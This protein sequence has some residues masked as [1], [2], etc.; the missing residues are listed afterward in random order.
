MT[1]VEKVVGS[2]VKIIHEV[3]SCDF[4]LKH[5]PE[6]H[7]DRC[8]NCGEIFCLKC[9]PEKILSPCQ[10]YIRAKHYFCSRVCRVEHDVCYTE[11][12]N[13]NHTARGFVSYISAEVRSDGADQS[14]WRCRGETDES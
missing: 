14:Q 11:P 8:D 13:I 2:D 1:S 4:C 7:L 10:K 3:Y 9:V 5:F 12:C 6:S